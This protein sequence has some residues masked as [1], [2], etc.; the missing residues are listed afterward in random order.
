[1]INL[2]LFSFSFISLITKLFSA[3]T[4]EHSQRWY[5]E[6]WETAREAQAA[7]IEQAK[8]APIKVNPRQ[9]IENRAPQD[10]NNEANPKPFLTSLSSQILVNVPPPP[11]YI[12][13]NTPQNIRGWTRLRDFMKK[14]RL[15]Q[16]RQME[17][18]AGGLIGSEVIWILT[19]LLVVVLETT[20]FIPGVL[21]SMQVNYWKLNE[22]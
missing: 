7:S 18:I 12:Q 11:I 4:V 15:V 16:A 1:M 22:K 20:K 3:L 8:N 17:A 10:E 9:D 5:D 6:V 21:T 14:K 2:F 19:I 13:L